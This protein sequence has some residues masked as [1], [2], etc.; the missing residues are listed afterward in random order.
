MAGSGSEIALDRAEKTVPTVRRMSFAL[1]LRQKKLLFEVPFSKRK[2]ERQAVPEDSGEVKRSA[3]PPVR[4]KRG[5]KL[6]ADGQNRIRGAA[7]Q[8]AG[9]QP[10]NSRD[11]GAGAQIRLRCVEGRR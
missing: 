8:G 6:R 11:Q 7:E 9:K 2:Y 10:R 4:R 3:G 5:S 1:S